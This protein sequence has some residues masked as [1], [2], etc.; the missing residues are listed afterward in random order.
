MQTIERDTALRY[1]PLREL[2]PKGWNEGRVD[3]GDAQIHYY[4]TGGTKPAVLLVHGFQSLGAYWLRT[5]QALD[6]RFDVVMVDLPGHGDFGPA[7]T[8]DVDTLASD[9]R[10]VIDALQLDRPA[11]AGHSLGGGIV[12]RLAAVNPGVAR[13]LILIDP[14]LSMP[15]SIAAPDEAA[16]AWQRSWIEET[17]RF[18]QLPHEQ[19]M[20]SA[21][22]R[23]PASMQLWN[24]QD[25][26]AMVEGQARLDLDIIG[27]HDMGA[28]IPDWPATVAAIDA[29]ILLLTGD[30]ARGGGYDPVAVDAIE[31]AWQTGMLVHFPEAGHFLDRDRFEMVVPLLREFAGPY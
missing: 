25:Y 12:A 30:P 23:W 9:L 26:V 24:E 29:P 3:T 1:R 18:Q 31:G 17:R 19:R 4:R 6:D 16:L 22:E 13:A 10:A 14:A 11:L 27:R 7:A 21:L 2:I 5:A 15:A 20:S 28:L 8:F